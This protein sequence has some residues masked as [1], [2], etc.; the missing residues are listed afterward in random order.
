MASKADKPPRMRTMSNLFLVSKCARAA[1]ASSNAL[2]W[3][4]AVISRLNEPAYGE[5]GLTIVVTIAVVEGELGEVARP[6]EVSLVPVP[7]RC[8]A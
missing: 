2:V 5:R 8:E 1:S 6:V 7:E 3:L 4:P